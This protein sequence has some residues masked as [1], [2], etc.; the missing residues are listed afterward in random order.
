[1]I[2]PPPNVNSLGGTSVLSPP[3]SSPAAIQRQQIHNQF[4]HSNDLIQSTVLWGDQRNDISSLHSQ[5]GG[6]SM[7]P[8][9]ITSSSL[10]GAYSIIAHA[11]ARPN[12]NSHNSFSPTP[13]P[14]STGLSITASTAAR[15]QGQ[16]QQHQPLSGT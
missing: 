10:D 16:H 14:S 15:L 13:S 9:H 12:S 7:L 1:M 5:T 6:V 8:P 2:T 4:G 11:A 3:I